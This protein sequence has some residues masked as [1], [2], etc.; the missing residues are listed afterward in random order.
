MMPLLF[1]EKMLATEL[2]RCFLRSSPC[3]TAF[4]LTVCAVLLCASV[5]YAYLTLGRVKR[6]DAPRFIGLYAHR[7]LH[8]DGVPENSL[9]AF[10]AALE[11]GYGVELDVHIC[12]DGALIVHHDGNIKRLTGF[13]GEISKMTS[14]EL[15]TKRLSGTEHTIPRFSEVLDLVGGKVP[16]I[17]ELKCRPEVDPAPLCERAMAYLDAYKESTGGEY[18]VESFDPYVVK[19]LRQNRPDVFRGQLTEAFYTRG[20]RTAA[21]FFMEHLLINYVG[22]PDFTAYNVRDRKNLSLRVWRH[23]YKAPTAIWTVRSQEELDSAKRAL[24]DD[25]A[26]IFE[27]FIPDGGVR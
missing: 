14:D 24:G 21:M 22:R 1:S 10:D 8:S 27:G 11:R 25:I 18:C 3:A 2:S 15:V 6:P 5:V 19:W 7:G 16:L 23:I 17:V 20:K 12:A 4:F 9:A 13:D 26:I